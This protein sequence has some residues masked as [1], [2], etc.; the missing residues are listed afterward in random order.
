[1]AGSWENAA[2]L[3]RR[4]TDAAVSSSHRT[5]LISRLEFWAAVGV[6]EGIAAALEEV[7]EVVVLAAAVSF[8]ASVA[9]VV[10][11]F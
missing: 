9:A 2:A 3:L 8:F 10:V 5:I 6:V 7:A 4:C 1:M 11:V